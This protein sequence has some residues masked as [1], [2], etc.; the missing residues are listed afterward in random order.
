MEVQKENIIISKLDSI[1]EELNY[2]KEH[3]IERDEI[4]VQEEFEAY[5]RTFEEENLISFEEVKKKLNL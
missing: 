5:N 4:M 3:M 2:I 1:Q